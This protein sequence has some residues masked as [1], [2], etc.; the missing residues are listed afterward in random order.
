MVDK[1]L[2]NQLQ[3]TLRRSF[4][5]LCAFGIFLVA[6]L[7]L[8]Q[9]Y[10]RPADTDALQSL[11][12]KIVTALEGRERITIQLSTYNAD[13]FD[14]VCIVYDYIDA[15]FSLNLRGLDF[16]LPRSGGP[17]TED[18]QYALA[19]VAQGRAGFVF[20]PKSSMSPMSGD[21]CFSVSAAILEIIP[22]TPPRGAVFRLTRM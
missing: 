15:F 3:L 6:W 10:L 2:H 1:G 22:Q 18:G 14:I 7:I 20:F 5:I 13:G 21:G 8:T 9:E 16:G 4:V 12:I 17:K 19:F 11:Q